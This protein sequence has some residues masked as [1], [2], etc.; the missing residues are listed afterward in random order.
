[1]KQSTRRTLVRVGAIV[2][3]GL[4]IVSAAWTGIIS[5]LQSKAE[6]VSTYPPLL[7]YEDEYYVLTSQEVE[8][9]PDGLTLVEAEVIGDQETVPYESGTCNFGNGMMVFQ[10]GENEAYCEDNDGSWLICQKLTAEEEE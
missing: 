1:M 7:F 9:L 10:V 2:M 3:A 4:I 8:Q 6:N 5:M